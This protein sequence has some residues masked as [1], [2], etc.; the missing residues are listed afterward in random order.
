MHYKSEW[1]FLKQGI[2]PRKKFH[3]H[4]YRSFSQLSQAKPPY[5]QAALTEKLKK[6]A[7]IK[8]Q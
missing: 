1:W 5:A 3:V 7:N 6:K 2:T 4:S 8:E